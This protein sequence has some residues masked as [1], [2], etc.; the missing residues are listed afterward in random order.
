MVTII[1]ISEPENIIA[2][3]HQQRFL[4]NW[5]RGVV[6]MLGGGLVGCQ[7]TGCANNTR[8]VYD[9]QGT[10]HC[11]APKYRGGQEMH[12]LLGEKHN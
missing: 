10:I 1:E 5:R 6:K 7:S 8:L 11:D 3:K 4:N 12:Y 9:S 2:R